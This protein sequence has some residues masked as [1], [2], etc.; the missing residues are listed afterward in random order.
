MNENEYILVAFRKA[1]FESN[2]RAYGIQPGRLLGAGVLGH[3]LGALTDGVFGQLTGEK[4]ANRS[5]D[6]P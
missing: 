6:L 5:L 2:A 3:R 1:V 4:Q